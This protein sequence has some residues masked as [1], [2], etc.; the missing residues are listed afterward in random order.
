MMYL[1]VLAAAL[2]LL[3]HLPLE[4]LTRLRVSL[5]AAPKLEPRDVATL[6]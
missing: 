1:A 5:E 4:R 6:R 2:L 3:P